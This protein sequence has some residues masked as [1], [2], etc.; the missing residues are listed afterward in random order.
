MTH[1]ISADILAELS[2]DSPINALFDEGR[3]LSLESRQRI[4]ALGDGATAAL[5]AI[6]QDEKLWDDQAP[7]GGFAPIYAAEIL[8]ET[9]DPQALKA[10]LEVYARVDPDALLDDALTAAIRAYGQPAI[11]AGL[12]QLSAWDDPFLERLAR[13][14][15]TMNFQLGKDSPGSASKAHR[16]DAKIHQQTLQVLLKH[17]LSDPILGAELLVEFG[18]PIAID[19]LDVALN[20]YIVRAGGKQ[21]FHRPILAL[22]EAIEALGG[23]L[24]TEQQNELARLKHAR[25]PSDMV[26]DELLDKKQADDSRTIRLPARPRRNQP[27]WCG[28]GRKYKRCHLAEDQSDD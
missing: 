13:L 5:L 15:S 21:V 19:A 1:E 7:G 6:L 2:P 17:F 4:S 22:A 20:R 27:C 26:T 16:F 11:P 8:G 9:Q 24:S 14:F 23:E 10:L 18:D 12:R 3:A 28:S 25:R